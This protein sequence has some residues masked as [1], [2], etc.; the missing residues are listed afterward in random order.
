MKELISNVFKY[1]KASPDV[2]IIYT[3][4][5]VHVSLSVVFD[6]D[7][8]LYSVYERHRRQ[9]MTTEWKHYTLKY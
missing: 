1:K 8:I 5:C 6:T 3:S 4:V 7:F 9:Q 2:C